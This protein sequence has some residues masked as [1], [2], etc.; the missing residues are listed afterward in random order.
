MSEL[1]E[2]LGFHWPFSCSQQSCCKPLIVGADSKRGRVLYLEILSHMQ[3]RMGINEYDA[4]KWKPNIALSKYP[5]LRHLKHSPYI[6]NPTDLFSPA[7]FL[8]FFLSFFVFFKEK[9]S[10]DLAENNKPLKQ[11]VSILM[12]NVILGQL[13]GPGCTHRE[14]SGYNW[15]NTW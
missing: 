9:T 12:T 7:S 13:T 15:D 1:P 11:V 5:W 4:Q 8:L 6:F 3:R 10:S 2:L 14:L